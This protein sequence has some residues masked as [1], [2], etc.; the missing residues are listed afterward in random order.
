MI[1]AL[2]LFP[3]VRCGWLCELLV[4]PLIDNGDFL[5][6][7]TEEMYDIALRALAHGDDTVGTKAGGAELPMVDPAVDARIVVRETQED[8]VVDGDHALDAFRAQSPGQLTRE[9]VE[10]PHLLTRRSADDAPLAP[11]RTAKTPEEA[12][13]K[14]HPHRRQLSDVTYG[15]GFLRI[16]SKE[17]QAQVGSPLRQA[18]DDKTTVITQPR[19]VLRSPFAVEA[20]MDMLMCHVVKGLVRRG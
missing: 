2:H 9:S 17:V 10:E 1:A 13:G 12:L 7:G 16:G 20:Y 18:A 3:K 11:Q 8:E 19:F 5:L 6:G 15:L 14:A 4:A